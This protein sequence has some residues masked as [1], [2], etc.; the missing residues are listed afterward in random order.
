[1]AWQLLADEPLAVA[2][3]LVEG[4]RAGATDEELG[5]ALAYAAACASCASTRA[6]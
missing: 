2:D 5:R 1:V 4:T 6:T 3:A